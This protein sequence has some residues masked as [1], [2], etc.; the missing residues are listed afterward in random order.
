M[1]KNQTLLDTLFIILVGVLFF[2]AF[3]GS[4]H[5]ITPD[6]GRYVEVA[7]EMVASNNY[8]TPYLNGTAFLDK[9]ILYYWF[10]SMLIKTFGLSEWSV[11]LLPAFFGLLGCLLTY[12]AGTKLYN[13]RTGWI[14]ALILMSSLLYFLSSHY[15]DMD[16]MVA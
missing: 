1:I 10:E 5:L 13:R 7:R 16:L 12:W 8:I 14:A 6:E 15:A 3:I 2:G 9:P 11:R 4:Y